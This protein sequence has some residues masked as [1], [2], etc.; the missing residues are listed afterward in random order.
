MAHVLGIDLGGT[1]VLAGVVDVKSGKILST[2]K[3][4]S[5]AQHGPDIIKTHLEQ[6]RST[7]NSDD[8]ANASANGH[9]GRCKR[10]VDAHSRQ[11]DF[12]HSV[13]LEANNRIGTRP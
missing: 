3:K 11:G 5:A 9:I 8:C 12:R 4:R 10:F 2:A 7:E 6:P 1:K 13:I